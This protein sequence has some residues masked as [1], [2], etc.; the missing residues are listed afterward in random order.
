MPL[1][2]LTAKCGDKKSKVVCGAFNKT[3][4]WQDDVCTNLPRE[5][6]ARR[7]NGA[8]SATNDPKMDCR[9]LYGE[10]FLDPSYGYVCYEREDDDD[11]DDADANA[12][13]G[14][15]VK[16]DL[17]APDGSLH[18]RNNKYSVDLVDTATGVA[19]R[20][21]VGGLLHFWSDA[22]NQAVTWE[23]SDDDAEFALPVTSDLMYKHPY[24]G[25]YV[26]SRAAALITNVVTMLS[27]NNA[28]AKVMVFAVPLMSTGKKLLG[29]IDGSFGASEIH[30]TEIDTADIPDAFAQGVKCGDDREVVFDNFDNVTED[31]MELSVRTSAIP[32]RADESTWY[33]VAGDYYADNSIMELTRLMCTVIPGNGRVVIGTGSDRFSRDLAATFPSPAQQL[34]LSGG[35]IAATVKTYATQAEIA[36]ERQQVNEEW[37]RLRA[38]RMSVNDAIYITRRDS[39]LTRPHVAGVQYHPG[40]QVPHGPPSAKV[41][42]MTLSKN[43][44]MPTLAEQAKVAYADDF[45]VALAEMH[46]DQLIG[47]PEPTVVMY[48]ETE[49]TEKP[50]VAKTNIPGG[51]MLHTTRYRT[52]G[53]ARS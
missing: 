29:N 45:M 12:S 7:R 26:N 42:R 53:E 51:V 44:P 3:C 16:L 50:V 32:R 15:T 28:E 11:E 18:A 6:V 30:G 8:Y 2:M 38:Q 27:E 47:T 9:P 22:N 46:A 4:A 14:P 19:V 48:F 5:D 41:L 17:E 33:K 39:A 40:T 13:A 36:Q 52:I 34:S 31:S 37:E 1:P 21:S 10:E 43:I 20:V 24:T 35:D 23:K 25:A 49:S